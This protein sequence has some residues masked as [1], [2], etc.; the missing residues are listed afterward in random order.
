MVLALQWLASPLLQGSKTKLQ[1]KNECIS[2]KQ[3]LLSRFESE[4]LLFDI[5]K[6][7]NSYNI[8]KFL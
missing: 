3:I 2:Q 5:V 4:I 1:N 8:L 6:S 7:V